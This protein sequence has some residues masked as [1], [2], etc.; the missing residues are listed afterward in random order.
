MPI[1]GEGEATKL[2]EGE[3]DYYRDYYVQ[4]NYVRDCYVRENYV[5]PFRIAMDR[6]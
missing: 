4:D 2:G 3:R 6:L 1:L 5:A